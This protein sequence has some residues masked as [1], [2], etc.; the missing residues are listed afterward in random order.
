MKLAIIHIWIIV[1]CFFS[2]LVYGQDVQERQVG[3]APIEHRPLPACAEPCV[4]ELMRNTSCGRTDFNCLCN[5]GLVSNDIGYCFE[6]HCLPSVRD[7]LSKSAQNVTTTD[8]GVVD[9]EQRPYVKV[10]SITLG[11]LALTCIVLRL[12]ERSDRRDKLRERFDDWVI[13]VNGILVLAFTIVG[14]ELPQRGMGRDSYTLPFQVLELLMK[15]L[16]THEV[17]YVAIVML[18]KLSILFVYLRI[19][20]VHAMPKLRMAIPITM[21]VVVAAGIAQAVAMVFQCT[22]VHYVWDSLRDTRG[23]HCININAWGWANASI[24]VALDTWL[25]CLP[26]PELFKLKLYWKKKLR[27]I[28]LF[29]VGS[30]VILVAIPR[31]VVMGSFQRTVNPTWKIPHITFVSALEAYVSVICACLP[32]IYILFSRLY[33]RY[34]GPSTSDPSKSPPTYPVV[35]TLPYIH[36]RHNIDPEGCPDNLG[37]AEAEAHEIIFSSPRPDSSTETD[38]NGQ[39]ERLWRHHSDANSSDSNTLVHACGSKTPMHRPAS[40]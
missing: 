16:I 38:S 5:H 32:R 21:G 33:H 40:V 9:R 28:L 12:L 1:T 13:I 27:V 35:S 24:N 17:L 7:Y 11:M 4:Q 20:P 19:F 23:G 25:I 30:L 15:L 8:C 18:T 29:I 36:P 31:L 26:L 34:G 14:V 3:P 10:T 39:G 2:T 6:T 37:S 22:P